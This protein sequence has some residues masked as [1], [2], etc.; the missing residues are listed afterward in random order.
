MNTSMIAGK[1]I[2]AVDDEPDV[3]EIIEE[4]LDEAI[5]DTARDFETAAQMLAD[6]DYDLAILDVMGVDGLTLLD[7]SV[8]KGIP[9]VIFTAHAMNV[10]TFQA[11]IEKGAISFLPKERMADLYRFINELIAI[12]ESGKEPWKILFDELAV[13]FDEKFGPDWKEENKSF[14]DEFTQMIR[15]RFAT[16]HT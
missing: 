16:D 9:A 15:T 8:A 13:Y 14:W 10:Q 1:R 12:I 3:L 5:L 2:L 7:I 11:V 4:I 6:T